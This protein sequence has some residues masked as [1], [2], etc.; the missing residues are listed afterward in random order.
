M[1]D[2]YHKT[3]YQKAYE[4]SIL[5]VPGV[6]FFKIDDHA[7]IEPPPIVKKPGRPRK[8]RVRASNEPASAK[9]LSR[10]GQIQH[11]SICNVVRHKRNRCSSSQNQ[12][13]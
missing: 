6:K 4:C 3:T 9:H 11:C 10:I 5:P 13:Q 1:S 7:P 2:W 12:V 8:K